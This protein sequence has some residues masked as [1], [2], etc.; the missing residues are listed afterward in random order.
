M[1]EFVPLTISARAPGTFIVDFGKNSLGF[2]RLQLKEPLGAR[3]TLRHA[4]ALRKD[5]ARMRANLG[6]AVCTD[7]V[8][9]HRLSGLS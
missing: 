2:V 3:V 1:R 5:G 7:S 8:V 9:C 4:E 6:Q